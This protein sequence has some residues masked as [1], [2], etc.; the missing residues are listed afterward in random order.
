[1]DF[2]QIKLLILDV[3][4]VL[5]D[6]SIDLS[7]E[8][9][10]VKRFCVRDGFAIKFWQRCGGR[11]A[12]ITGR[13]GDIVTRRSRELGITEVWSD[14]S[15]KLH[16]YQQILL[17]TKTRD[18]EVAYMGDDGP[19][20]EPMRCCGFSIAPANAAMSVKQRAD[21]ITR[22]RGGQGAVS[23]AIELILRKQGYWRSANFKGDVAGKSGTTHA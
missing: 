1:M 10:H 18:E 14:V 11:L 17:N 21:F 22:R 6:G 13:P 23:E 12:I 16:A 7:V 15:D 4:G 19:D 2:K 3:D 20:L 9:E 5:T 8:G